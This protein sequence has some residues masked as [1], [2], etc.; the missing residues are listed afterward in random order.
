MNRR[1]AAQIEVAEVNCIGLAPRPLEA[2]RLVEQQRD[3]PHAGGNF[4]TLRGSSSVQDAATNTSPPKT[5]IPKV[6]KAFP[7]I[8]NP[9]PPTIKATKEPRVSKARFSNHQFTK[10][11]E[12]YSSC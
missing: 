8:A 11:L 10:R 6:A 2:G 4:G 3:V 9:M 5:Q 7:A 1:G 12:L